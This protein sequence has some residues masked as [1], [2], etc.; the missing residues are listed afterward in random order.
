MRLFSILRRYANLI[1][2]DKIRDALQTFGKTYYG[3]ADPDINEPWNYY[4]FRRV[5]L[6]KTG[7]A[8]VGYN[9][10]YVV[11]IVKENYIPEGH[12]FE[13]INAICE[14]TGLKVAEEDITYSYTFKGSTSLVVEVALIPFVEAFKRKCE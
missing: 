5:R 7:T 11:A 12:E 2:L 8:N 4:V 6:R 13:I 9:R 14:A 3:N 1:K 10:R